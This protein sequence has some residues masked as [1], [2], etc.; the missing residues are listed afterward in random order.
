MADLVRSGMSAGEALR[1]LSLRLQ[2][3]KLRNLCAGLWTELG[4]GQS[5]S[6]AMSAY[7]AVFDGQ[8]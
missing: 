6:A 1:L 8:P 3:S 5:L 7:P 4:E 2:K